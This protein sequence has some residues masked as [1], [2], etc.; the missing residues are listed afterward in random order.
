MSFP[1]SFKYVFMAMWTSYTFIYFIF[2]TVPIL[3][4]VMKPLFTSFLVFFISLIAIGQNN[5][6]ISYGGVDMDKCDDINIT[7]DGTGNVVIPGV[8]LSTI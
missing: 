2:V 4:P 8:F 3:Y 1:L 5:L 6:Q 7:P